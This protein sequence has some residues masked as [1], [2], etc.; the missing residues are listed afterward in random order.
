[1]TRGRE[2]RR[3]KGGMVFSLTHTR[4]R[5]GLYRHLAVSTTTSHYCNCTTRL[6][7][8]S[9]IQQPKTCLLALFCLCSSATKATLRLHAGQTRVERSRRPCKYP[10]LPHSFDITIPRLHAYAHHDVLNMHTTDF[11]SPVLCCPTG[12]RYHD[13]LPIPIPI[14][15][16][17]SSQEAPPPP[18]TC[19]LHV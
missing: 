1:M 11:A 13:S 12:Y 6:L 8:R 9:P 5:C 18:L 7:L 2:R 19:C 14:H 16:S 3:A 10:R 4:R 17:P 15:S